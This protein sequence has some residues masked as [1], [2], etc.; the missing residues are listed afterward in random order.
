MKKFVEKFRQRRIE[1]G[2]QQAEVGRALRR[3]YGNGLSQATVC[4]FEAMKHSL[5]SMNK[6]KRI[7]EDWLKRT[8]AGQSG[9]A[10]SQS[11]SNGSNMENVDPGE[12]CYPN[13]HEKKTNSSHWTHPEVPRIWIQETKLLQL[14]K[15]SRGLRTLWDWKPVSSRFGSTIVDRER[16]DQF[17]VL[18]L[19]R[20]KLLQD[21]IDTQ[22]TSYTYCDLFPN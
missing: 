15:K 11:S 1:M 4:H 19:L 13:N 18:D 10:S 9:D 16:S 2:L 12:K 14:G 22:F 17:K 6:L 20:I 7:L 5:A 8:E 21:L 3:I